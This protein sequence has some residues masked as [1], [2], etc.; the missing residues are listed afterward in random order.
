MLDGQGARRVVVIGGGASAR[1]EDL[2]VANG[3]WTTG[4]GGGIYVD[5]GEAIVSRCTISNNV[6]LVYYGAGIAVD[7]G[8]RLMMTDS[9]IISNSVQYG[10][11]GEA[12]HLAH[13]RRCTA[14]GSSRT[15][16]ATAAR[17][18]RTRACSRLRPT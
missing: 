13:G 9:L 8:S 18:I 14:T 10:G 11:G 6:V 12:S 2:T 17:S 5:S 4:S 16:P 7:P 15:R 1:L 3:R